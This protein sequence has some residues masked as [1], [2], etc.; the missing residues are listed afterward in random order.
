MKIFISGYGKM[1]KKVEEVIFSRNIDYLGH[2]DDIQNTDNKDFKN[3]ICIDF[4]TPAAFIANYK[5]LADNFKA[6][7]VGTT[8]W[9]H[10]KNEIFEYFLKAKTALIWASNFSIGVIAVMQA[11][12]T[13]SKILSHSTSYTS[14]IVETHHIHKLDAPSGTA[15]SLADI[16]GQNMEIPNIESI[17]EGEVN[18]IHE[19]SFQS[20]ND[21]IKLKHEA[22]SRKAFAEGAVDAA[23]MIESLEGIHEFKELIINK[24]GL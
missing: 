2:S 18:G 24:I 19:L 3:A 14:N 22:F 5:F 15:K 4:S 1:G 10:H 7:V 13:I 23:T 12:D 9:H 6:V 21:C 20:E 16:V 17:R 11:A 8:G